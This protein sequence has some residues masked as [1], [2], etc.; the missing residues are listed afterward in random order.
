MTRDVSAPRVSGWSR[1]F[2][3]KNRSTCTGP[4]HASR[5]TGEKTIITKLV[6]NQ[7]WTKDEGQVLCEYLQCGNYKNHSGDFEKTTEWWNKTYNCTGKKNIYECER[8][9]QIVTEQKQLN[10]KCDGRS[11]KTII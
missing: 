6:S 8:D 9:D 2:L 1:L 11:Y 4:V 7:G 3:Y 10:I 5:S